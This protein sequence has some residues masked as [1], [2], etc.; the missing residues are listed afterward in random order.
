M[1]LLLIVAGCF[2]LLAIAWMAFLPTVVERQLSAVTGFDVRI[3][4]LAANPFTGRVTVEGFTVRNPPSFPRPDFVEVR[5]LYADVN[6]FSGVM[7]DRLLVNDLDLDAAKVEIVTA[8]DGRSNLSALQ[9]AFAKPAGTGASPAAPSSPSKP[10]KYLVHRLHVKL[11]RLVVV[12]S[13]GGAAREKVYELHIDHTYSDISSP[14]QLLVPDVL[15][16][17]YPFGA[18]RDVAHLIPGDFGKALGDAAGGA[19]QIG[20]KAKDLEK[21][22]KDAF[23][24]FLD[25]LEH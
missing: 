24:G 20:A 1:R 3:T 7:D 4:S 22:A 2:G 23:R 8:P 15:R 21:K 11:D 17:L 12:D 18:S 9:G 16:A 14:T 13:S 6:E 10:F 19:A 5:R 25:K